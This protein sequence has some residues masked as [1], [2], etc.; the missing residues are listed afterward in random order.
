M[1][2]GQSKKC[3]LAGGEGGWR[4][5]EKRLLGLLIKHL[6]LYEKA[7]TPPFPRKSERDR[8]RER[9]IGREREG[10]RERERER[11]GD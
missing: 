1:L 3:V 10:A 9:E 2:L 8:E 6:L 4:Q 7:L 5:V 11:E